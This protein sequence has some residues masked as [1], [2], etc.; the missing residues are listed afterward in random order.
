M[1]SGWT[2]WH[3]GVLIPWPV[4]E[5]IT[6]CY[7]VGQRQYLA[8]LELLVWTPFVG[9]KSNVFTNSMDYLQN[10]PSLAAVK[11][12][13]LPSIQS[14]LQVCCQALQAVSSQIEVYRYAN[15]RFWSGTPLTRLTEYQFWEWSGTEGSL[16]SILTSIFR[17][18]F[19]LRNIGISS[20]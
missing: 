10:C 18:T 1:V 17:L 3:S 16:F 6:W 4:F 2:S 15:C 12:S 8:T 19:F 20:Y 11:S 13:L 5:D 9:V 14:Q 7:V